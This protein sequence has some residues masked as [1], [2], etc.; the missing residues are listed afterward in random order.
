MAAAPFLGATVS[1]VPG[2][3]ND[4]VIDELAMRSLPLRSLAG[5]SPTS[6][7]ARDRK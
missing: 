6:C 5:A 2:N 7:H 4:V 1:G 3:S